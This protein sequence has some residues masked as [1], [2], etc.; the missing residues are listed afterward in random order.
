M[1]FSTVVTLHA[2]VHLCSPCLAWGCH[3]QGWQHLQPCRRLV[4]QAHMS[5]TTSPQQP[6][7]WQITRRHVWR[8]QRERQGVGGKWAFSCSVRCRAG[9]PLEP[10]SA[11]PVSPPP[12]WQSILAVSC[13]WQRFVRSATQPVSLQCH[14]FCLVSALIETYFKASKEILQFSFLQNISQ[15]K[16][17][18]VV[19]TAIYWANRLSVIKLLVFNFLLIDFK[20]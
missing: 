14:L 13:D 15:G 19:I 9:Y 8:V 4:L 5:S 1:F 7:P 2:R 20:I 11:V 10:C 18:F 12:R 6:Q 3:Q 17:L 16:W